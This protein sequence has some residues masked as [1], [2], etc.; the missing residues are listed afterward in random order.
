MSLLGGLLLL[1]PASSA[2]SA[3]SAES[4][5]SAEVTFLILL[6]RREPS[7][8]EDLRRTSCSVLFSRFLDALAAGVA[9]DT[10]FVDGAT[11]VDGAML[12][13]R[14]RFTDCWADEAGARFWVFAV[15]QSDRV[16]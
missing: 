15:W 7:V 9:V 2:S 4:M 5:N 8:G 10:G 11:L 3:S 13:E 14:L 6:L 16:G 1:D 12:V